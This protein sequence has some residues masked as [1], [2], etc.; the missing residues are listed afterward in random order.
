MREAADVAEGGD[1]VRTFERAKQIDVGGLFD[2]LAPDRPLCIG[3]GRVVAT[4]NVRARPV[5]DAVRLERIEG[6]SADPPA[7]RSGVLAPGHVGRRGGVARAAV[8]E[9]FPA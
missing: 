9:T 6:E 1:Q 4:P 2:T 7:K 3:R 8:L 5:E